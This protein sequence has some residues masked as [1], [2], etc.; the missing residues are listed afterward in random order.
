MPAAVATT[1]EVTPDHRP[2]Q[3]RGAALRLMMDKSP[4]VVVS[5]PA[6]TGKSRAAL[7]KLHLWCDNV[8]KIRAL[9]VRKTR[10]SLSESALVTFEE[11]VVPDGHPVLATGGQRRMRQAYRYPNGSEIVVGGIDKPGKI[12]STEYDF[13]FVQEAIELKE[14]DWEALTTRLRNHVAPYQQL[15]ADTN[16]D[17]PTHWLKRR[18]EAGRCLMLESRHEDN[19]TVTPE[20]LAKLDALTGPRKQRLR[21]G[22]WVQAE[23]VVYDGFD[24]LIHVIDRFTP[25]ETWPRYWSIDFGYTNPFVCQFWAKD[26]DGRLYLYREIYRTQTIV[27]D[28]AKRIRE[29]SRDEPRPSAIICDHDAE[30]RATLERH[31]PIRTLPANKTITLGIQTVQ[32]QLRPAG[33]GKPR[34]FFMADTVDRRDPALMESKKPCCTVEEFDSYVWNTAANRKHGEEPLDEHNHGMDAMRYM[35]MHFAGKP[36]VSPPR[37]AG[38]GLVLPG[39]R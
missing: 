8:P 9:V 37:N 5:G 28:H 34:L 22:R 1:A 31:L 17:A 38:G 35:V 14:E 27:E 12:M 11:K 39:G 29:V 16:P 36:R 25:H 23:G 4:E 15:L 32:A 21:H 13:I 26:P 6:G 30:G 10:E 24:R 20:Y 18:C 3:P 19:P 33:D 7:E 2:Y